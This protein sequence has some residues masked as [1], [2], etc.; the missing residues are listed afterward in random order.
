V[1]SAP[2][3]DPRRAQKL[4]EALA[5]MAPWLAPRWTG[6]GQEG[7]FG[8]ALYEIAARLAEQ[9]TRRLD[10]T[11]LRDKL[12]FLDTLDIAAPAPRSASVP[13]VFRLAESRGEPVYAPARVQI[14]A[15]GD[16]KPVI[17]ETVEG[18]AITP[19]RPLRLIAADP[20]ADRIELAP[21]AVTA[22]PKPSPPP[23]TYRLVSAA[24]PDATTLQLA[25]SVGL[26]AGDLL[27]IAGK[28]YRIAKLAGEIVTLLDPLE[29]AA[30]AG[31]AVERITRLESFGL[32]NLNQHMLFVSHKELLKLDSE[33]TI[34]LRLDPPGLVRRLT[35][36][37]IAYDLWA[38]PKGGAA[39]W[40][41]LR[42]LGG[43]D[44][45][46]RLLKDWPGSVEE[47]EVEGRKSRW[48]RL[49][50]RTPIADSAPPA[51]R[52]ASLSLKVSS[53]PPADPAAAAPAR[54]GSRSIV[55]AFYN[56]LPLPLTS[57]FLPFGPEPQR[58]DTFAIAAPE[59]L[60]KRQATVTL[61]VTL[62][63]ASL[64]AMALT[65]GNPR[66]VYGV[67]RNQ[68][69]QAIRFEGGDA[70]WRQL[71]ASPAAA[72]A[73]AAAGWLPLD[74]RT[75]LYALASAD[76][77]LDLV[78]GFDKNNLLRA[79]Q[80]RTSGTAWSIDAWQDLGPPADTQFKAFCL[81]AS[82]Q[83]NRPSQLMAADK[84]GVS[85]RTVDP[86]GAVSPDWK[87]LDPSLAPGTSSL[88]VLDKAIMLAP[89]GQSAES[90]HLVLV[91]SAGALFHGEVAVAAD[92]VSWRR[93][94]DPTGTPADPAVR[95]AAFL[96]PE[97]KPVVVAARLA[98]DG[99]L[100]VPE[101]GGGFDPPE[102]VGKPVSILCLPDAGDSAS[103]LPL[104]VVTG[105]AGYFVWR[106]PQ[107]GK[108]IAMPSDVDSQSPHNALLLPPIS[109]GDGPTLLLNASKERLLRGPLGPLPLP[110][111]GSR[112]DVLR[113]A[114]ATDPPSHVA[115]GAPPKLFSLA[116]SW[117]Q[118]DG[119]P[120]HALAAAQRRPGTPYTL[121]AG[122]SDELK[123]VPVTGEKSALFLPDADKSTAAGDFLRIDGEVYEVTAV[124][125]PILQRTAT[126][127]KTVPG[128][129][130]TYAVWEAVGN[131]DKDGDLK[132]AQVSGPYN[133]V[134]ITGEARKLILASSDPDTQEDRYLVLAGQPYRVVSIESEM[135]KRKAVLD[136]N[137][138]G[139]GSRYSAFRPTE[140]AGAF[141]ARDLGTLV[142]LGA[143]PVP[144]D[145]TDL[146]YP[147]PADPAI[148]RFQSP[149]SPPA[150]GSSW[151]L[152]RDA[153]R[154]EPSGPKA[155]LAGK[156]AVGAWTQIQLPR[157]SD[158]P[159]LSWEY[160]DGRGWKRLEQGFRDET[161]NF[162]S[163]GPISFVVP[164]DIGPTDV[165]GKTDYWIR[166]RLIGGD[167]GRP[168]YSVDTS[169]AGRQSIR[170]DRSA[171]NPPE[172]VSIEAGYELEKY[173]QPQAVLTVNNLAVADQTQAAAERGA[174]FELFEGLAAHTGD[175][176][177][178]GRAIHLGLSRA[179]QVESLS[180]FIDAQ[181]VG[182][183]PLRL[184]AEVLRP[185]G[186]YP[187][188]SDDRTKGLTRP[189]LLRLFLSP[190]PVQSPLF[191]C[192]GWW[193]RLRTLEPSAN[194]APVVR[195][196]HLNAVDAEEAKSLRQ[197]ILGSSLGEPDQSYT[198]A[199]APVLPETVD[200]RVRES[201][202][203]E[204]KAALSSADPGS[205]A[206]YEDIEGEWVRWR[207]T[208]SFVAQGGGAR[209]FRLDPSTGEIRFGDGRDGKIPPAG[210][211][212][213]RAVAYQSGGGSRGNVRAFAV[214]QLKTA[215]ES[216]EL[217][218]NP[219]DSGGGADAPPDSQLAQTAPARL[220][221]AGRA[222]SPA[223]IEAIAT[224]SSPDV[225]R[226]RCLRGRGCAID[227]VVA[228]RQA[229]ERC[230]V[231]SRA[232]REGIG[233]NIAAVAWGAL[234]PDSIRVRAP[235]YV[236][237]KVDAVVLARSA[238]QVAQVEHD[239]REAILG[240]LHSTD[241]GPSGLGWPF[242]RRPWPSDVQ[243]V[244]AAV[245]GVD[246][247]ADV[248]IAALGAGVDLD[249]LGPDALVC[250]A[251]DDIALDVRPPESA[252]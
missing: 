22:A 119:G 33:A 232:R 132:I 192:D 24:E 37:D 202:S 94:T 142:D 97:G 169:V 184:Q 116:G 10:R 156:M 189:G 98:D 233:R 87:R 6:P 203:D 161:A 74:R 79:A 242:G 181:D 186:W 183:D 108:A 170:I 238:E 229:G 12:A 223:D 190:A 167:Y 31:T 176:A 1:S 59:A 135:L 187:V 63:D 164:V 162:A 225:V 90:A 85:R 55:S 243:R 23:V 40:Q 122:P 4:R 89:A 153:W 177:G 106:Y 60:T 101:P 58:F 250:V 131:A 145:M 245:A 61:E 47:V 96:D 95:P 178:L 44:G 180:L 19:A 247:V 92:A 216:V 155:I 210:R 43:P 198:L 49:S 248:S 118:F 168:A 72:A 46:L 5:E 62:S 147:P 175:P 27:R 204:E 246:R 206:S 36:L 230:P 213:I 32:R 209:V 42:L 111:S 26:A 171:I 100:V 252:R 51:T 207:A 191:G 241:G 158:A 121:L 114:Q 174:E 236:A 14:A 159:E 211:D 64:E 3:T 251:E 120:V 152:L 133:G 93:M 134:R 67:G 41:P 150:D 193:L 73:A 66:H 102:K 136:R 194:W 143:T 7:D 80:V 205:V 110:V 151:L 20:A 128:T 125:G 224:G 65:A 68:R 130:R 212:S 228:I 129:T 127:E 11:A 249:R 17:F 34:T 107:G 82:A 69:L 163:S 56:G 35:R 54:D 172:I 45:E 137:I 48:I 221:H 2:L 148:Q 154:T 195:G 173:S 53:A 39:D 222:L 84:A 38:K 78:F 30:A 123:G 13:I 235:E 50:L 105:P 166:A 208:D 29:S 109:P 104:T 220:R 71:D 197:E 70:H 149:S 77:D 52:A 179:P 83:A 218:V 18:I 239:V 28:A 126:L 141:A 160:F 16:S 99:L 196:L 115:V 57:A 199:E 15:P 113:S 138:A 185:D 214:A 140:P 231:P 200:L 182:A 21:E 240:F 144:A 201:L 165:A 234:A 76:P 75:P 9:S 139:G 219:V 8:A 217:A 25:Q 86:A 188:L 146:G 103:P 112:Y 237:M 244:A 81:I 91:D 88:P 215:L 157:S 227:L 226:A 124:T 117:L